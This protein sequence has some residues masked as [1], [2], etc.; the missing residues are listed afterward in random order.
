MTLIQ[1][2]A[3]ASLLFGLSALCLA[4]TA[5]RITQP[6]DASRVSVVPGNLVP[7]ATAE[8]DMGP[9]PADTQLS[10]VAI[11]FNRS[12]AQKADLDQ[13][14]AAQQDRTSPLYH[15]WLT[16]EQYGARFGLPASDIGQVKNWLTRQGFAIVRVARSSTEIVFSGTAAQ[17]NAALHT[18]LH[19][20]L[21]NGETHFANATEPSVPEAIAPV[22]LGFRNLSNFR[23]KPHVR[24]PDPQFTS[25]LSG[26]HFLVPDDFAT[27]YDLQSLYAAG[28]DGTGETI[29]IVGQSAVSNT[30]I[31]A[32]R[33]AANLPTTPAVTMTLV[34]GT[35]TSTAC[36]GDETE[37]DL[38]IEWAGGIAKNATINFV[39]VGVV[40]P[41]TCTTTTSSAF[42][43]ITYAVDNAVAPVISSS[44]GLC[45]AMLGQS[46]AMTV[47]QEAQQA[48]AQGETMVA[49]AGDDGAAD[50]D[51]EVSTAT[52]GLAVDVPAAV[53]E[54]TGLGGS[55]FL[56]DVNSPASYWNAS[57]NA[58]QG[59]AIQYIPEE[60]WNDTQQNISN[61]VT[62]AIAAGGGGA[63]IF[64]T[65]PT[66]Q[67]GTGVP[68]DGQRD[69]PDLA[70]SA[71]A[72]HDGYLI[73]SQDYFTS[74]GQ[75]LT[76]CAG[77][78]N[79]PFRASDGQSLAVVGG[80]SAAAPSFAAILAIINQATK[81]TGSG[82]INSVL[83]P[84]AATPN[85]FHD[86]TTGNNIV[87]C[88]QGTPNCP[89]T[90]P[91]QFGFSAGAGYDQVTGLG[92][93]D[94]FVL[95]NA[96]PNSNAS[97]TPTTVTVSSSSPTV[98][99]GSPV[100][101]SATIA[102]G[103][104]PVNTVQFL[105]DGTGFGSPIA[106]S[107]GK[108]A[109]QTSTI[110]GGSHSVTA[111]YNG[112]LNNLPSTSAA[113]T[114]VVSDF[115]APSA[116]P[117]SISLAPGAVGT[118]TLTISGESTFSGS[119]ALTCAA[120][121]TAAGITCSIAPTSVTLTNG[122]ASTMPTLTVTTSGS[123]TPAGSY[124]VTVT[125]T[126]GSTTHSSAV[127]LTVLDFNAPVASPTALSLAPGGMGTSSLTISAASGFNGSV[128]LTCTASSTTAGI[129][130]SIAPTSVTL[131]N[132]ATSTMP[133]LTVTTTG[134]SAALTKP[135]GMGWFLA[136]GSVGLA[137]IFMIGVP[138]RR[139]K[140]S[141]LLGLALFAFMATGVGCGGGSTSGGGGGGSTGTP[142]GSY[143][144]TVTG[145]SGSTTHATPVT[146]TVT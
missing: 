110:P 17:V 121:S 100:T 43:S 145:T 63:S 94:G 98:N 79:G 89:S 141:G 86:I 54:V 115:N 32:F 69:V 105:V 77:G 124:S 39:Y 6:V 106:V 51:F 44:Y 80:T 65:K 70:F 130:C 107:G 24:R 59:S 113:I 91:F 10:S 144:I 40:S 119:V 78:S 23:P 133:V 139:R 96:W 97:R 58:N 12:A 112:D 87:P 30:D 103:T 25:S 73:C 85:V 47:Q 37:S 52:M 127:A 21:I 26:N 114:Q 81:S 22:V 92:S 108:A 104:S 128:A 129:K 20:Y 102:G 75:S 67:T 19:Q 3:A 27:I 123:A 4:E 76:S 45:E 46:Y 13:L 41:L 61:G 125:G 7:V 138:T 74:Q 53:P 38:D 142:A 68:A 137:G 88:T 15:Q 36:T 71:S 31:D 9:L 93:V 34:P 135:A 64:F 1:K 117:T 146:L 72:N 49:A 28:F 143:T 90:S 134:P 33:T 116:S 50:C 16:P 122:A 57:N 2:C 82:N 83:Y 101:L 11:V 140:L 29:A 56:A 18:E 136:T 48:N 84:L 131:T 109:L 118:S 132:G 62:P 35:G 60:T 42:D 8:H 120:S 66:W 14:L 126:S 5:P 99:A 55:E 111:T 95:A